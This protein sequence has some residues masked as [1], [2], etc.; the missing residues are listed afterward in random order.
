MYRFTERSLIMKVT[1]LSLFEKMGAVGIKN[2]VTVT[3][4]RH[5]YKLDAHAGLNGQISDMVKGELFGRF[6]KSTK[7]IK[8]YIKPKGINLIK[9]NL[10]KIVDLEKLYELFGPNKPKATNTKQPDLNLSVFA[11]SSIE[12]IIQLE[13][14]RDQLL[15]FLLSLQAM[16]S[17]QLDKLLPERVQQ[18]DTSI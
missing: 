3:V 8:W 2:G 13:K 11:H 4:F 10:D 7:D 5:H 17:S 18:Q 1:I 14:D 12:G 16:I 9:E 6:G 15:R